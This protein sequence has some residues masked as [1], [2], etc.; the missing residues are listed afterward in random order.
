LKSL[1]K[2]LSACF[3][4]CVPALVQCGH[5][6]PVGVT[7][8][9]ALSAA[10]VSG[11]FTS[12]QCEPFDD[13][14]YQIRHYTFTAGGATATWDRFSDPLCSTGSKL[15][16]LVMSGTAKVT[17][18]SAQV[19]GAAD[20]TVSI[21]DK[22]IT[23]TAAGL[24]LVE[25]TCGQ[26]P[27]QADAVQD[28]TT[29]CGA[30]LQQTDDCPAEY[31]LIKLTLA[32]L[33]FGDRS[34]PLCSEATRPTALSE[35]AVVLDP[36]GYVSPSTPAD[37]PDA[38]APAEDGGVVA[39]ADAALIDVA[40]AI[41][42]GGGVADDDASASNPSCQGVAD[43]TYCGADGVNGDSDTLYQ[44]SGGIVSVI[45]VCSAGC[46]PS[47]DGADGCS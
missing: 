30:L 5:S 13:T 12:S 31:D 45:E 35:W 11:N 37:G 7:G 27:W 24:P 8:T 16:T 46:D 26:Y 6:A 20:I 19:L 14:T 43:G 23:P 17:G 1:Q 42:D 28:V 34:H 38:A 39:D 21:A 40:A 10:G 3:V 29:G 15:M 41:E 36:G 2:C 25:Q 33:V 44:C 4:A 47:G 22:T 32:G 18:L 9:E